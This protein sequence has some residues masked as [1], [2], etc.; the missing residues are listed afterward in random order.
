MHMSLME[1]RDDALDAG[2]ELRSTVVA[3]STQDDQINC[4]MKYGIFFNLRRSIGRIIDT[5]NAA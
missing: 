2:I 1:D 3:T 5:N 4:S